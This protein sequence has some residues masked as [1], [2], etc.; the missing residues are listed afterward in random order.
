MLYT[1]EIRGQVKEPSRLRGIDQTTLTDR[2]H[3]L[4]RNLK[5]F[6][7]GKFECFEEVYP[8]NKVS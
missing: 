8:C 3:A 5:T 6:S 4:Q 2:S 1:T 7:V